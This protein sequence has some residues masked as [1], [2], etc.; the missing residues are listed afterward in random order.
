[1]EHSIHYINEEDESLLKRFLLMRM[2]FRTRPA[3]ALWAGF[4]CL[5]TEVC[6]QQLF[7]AVGLGQGCWGARE[8]YLAP[9]QLLLLHVHRIIVQTPH[10]LGVLGFST[11]IVRTHSRPVPE[12]TV[13][14]LESVL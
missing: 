11:L 6:V 7:S 1:M 3:G 4:E 2:Q 9:S 14:D 10:P 8:C 12:P 5:L 13:Y